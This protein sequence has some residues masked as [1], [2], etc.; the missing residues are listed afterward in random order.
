MSMQVDVLHVTGPRNA[1]DALCKY[2][3]DIKVGLAA[4]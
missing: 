1:G 4:V 2:S 3:E